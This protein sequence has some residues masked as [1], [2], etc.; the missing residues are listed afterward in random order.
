MSNDAAPLP[1]D[2]ALCHQIIRDL[3]REVAKLKGEVAQLK[4]R[5]NQ[6]SSN[7]SKPPSLLTTEAKT[8]AA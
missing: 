3:H 7:S 4:T 2:V 8:A 6:N 1:D 5:L